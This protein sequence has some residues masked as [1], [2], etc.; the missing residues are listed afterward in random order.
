MAL[1]TGTN[2]ERVDFRPPATAVAGQKAGSL[3]VTSANRSTFE[4]YFNTYDIVYFD[5]LTIQTTVTIPS[6]KTMVV[7]NIFTM[8]DPATII[9]GP[10]PTSG[11]TPGDPSYVNHS[12]NPYNINETV[13]YSWDW[14]NN[15]GRSNSYDFP[16]YCFSST[17]SMGRPIANDD[18]TVEARVASYIMQYLDWRVHRKGGGGGGNTQGG[19]SSKSRPTGDPFGDSGGQGY[20]RSNY[21]RQNNYFSLHEHSNGSVSASWGSYNARVIWRGLASR[22]QLWVWKAGTNSETDRIGFFDNDPSGTL[23]QFVI[24]ANIVNF[25]G[26]LFGS[27]SISWSWLTWSYPYSRGGAAHDNM[28]VKAINNN[29]GFNPAIHVKPTATISNQLHGG[30]QGGAGRVWVNGGYTPD[31]GRAAGGGCIKIMAQRVNVTGIIKAEGQKSR[32]DIISSG[33]GNMQ[34]G[35]TSISSMRTAVASGNIV[36]DSG[37][38][39]GGFIWFVHDTIVGSFTPTVYLYGGLGKLIPYAT[40]TD[41]AQGGGHGAGGMW[42]LDCPPGQEG[43]VYWYN[44]TSSETTKWTDGLHPSGVV[45]T[46]L[47]SQASGPIFTITITS[48][49][50]N[51]SGSFLGVNTAN[52]ATTTATITCTNQLGSLVGGTAPVIS[53]WKPGVDTSNQS[54]AIV[55]KQAMTVVNST[56]GQYKYDYLYNTNSATGAPNG[57]TGTYTVQIIAGDASDNFSTTT[58]FFTVD[59][60]P[61]TLTSPSGNIGTKAGGTATVTVSANDTQSGVKSVIA[62]V[63]TNSSTYTGTAPVDTTM[64]FVPPTTNTLGYYMANIS[65]PSN[66]TGSFSVYFIATDNV[67]NVT[68]YLQATPI[69]V[70]IDNVAPVITYAFEPDRAVFLPGETGKILIFCDETG[71]SPTVTIALTKG[72]NFFGDLP[73]YSGITFSKMF[74]PTGST[75]PRYVFFVEF[76][77]GLSSIGPINAT[78]TATDP[79]GNVRTSSV[80]NLMQIIRPSGILLMS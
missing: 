73:T 71:G 19:N 34:R 29:G 21:V 10:N 18:G 55:N 2:N 12:A 78:I 36:A 68:T 15:R 31:P 8:L 6:G 72:D 61:P 48:N 74:Y 53:I 66:A 44:Q 7:K 63:V 62:K 64:T 45:A 5:D 52:S 43:T 14:G 30:S 60:T 4:S 40:D 65:V 17:D 11:P 27:D 22:L 47:I 35:F 80:T 59:L 58:S 39:S 76:N 9:V 75:I 28:S 13:S 79:A 38:G 24:S 33:Y 49:S 25:S 23:E 77:I 67:N 37:A 26:Q 50:S 1:I 57:S 3:T 54:L 56:T 20:G 41:T 42:R 51:I 69:V 46:S 70:S 32:A 16:K